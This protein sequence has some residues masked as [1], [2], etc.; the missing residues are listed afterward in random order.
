MRINPDELHC[1]DPQFVDEIF[2]IGTRKRN[3]PAHQLRSLEGEYAFFTASPYICLCSSRTEACS[4]NTFSGFGTADHNLHKLRRAPLTKFF[5]KHQITK[6]EAEV[7]KSVHLLCDELLGY[8]DSK[9]PFD[10]TSAY[11]CFT[12]DIIAEYCFGEKLGFLQQ[13]GIE[14]NFRRAIYSILNTTYVF[15]FIPWLKPLT[16]MVP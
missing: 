11:S 4:S 9:E 8:T 2:A 12:S 3:K 1:N 10:L 14:P 7:H 13:D 5:S 16:L 15:R 6:L